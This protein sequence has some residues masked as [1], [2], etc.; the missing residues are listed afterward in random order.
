MDG[1]FNPQLEQG[2]SI[3]N[4]TIH[5]KNK[6]PTEVAT[7]LRDAVLRTDRFWEYLDIVDTPT[8]DGYLV[9]R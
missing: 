9:E 4:S 3:G 8:F 1:Q 6:P 7:G 2:G 5:Q